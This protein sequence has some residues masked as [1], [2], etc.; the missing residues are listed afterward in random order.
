[1]KEEYNY[2]KS[3]CVGQSSNFQ[4]SMHAVRQGPRTLATASI[5]ARRLEGMSSTLALICIAR[6]GALNIAAS[7]DSTHSL[8]SKMNTLNPR[9]T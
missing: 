3:S 4:Y 7:P 2:F 9:K 5:C 6:R 1:M 8:T